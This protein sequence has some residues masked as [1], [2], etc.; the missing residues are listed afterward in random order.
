[1]QRVSDLQGAEFRFLEKKETILQGF[2]PKLRKSVYLFRAEDKKWAY[3]SKSINKVIKVDRWQDKSAFIEGSWVKLSVYHR[4]HLL[5]PNSLTYKG[6]NGETTVN[7]AIIPIT[8][9]AY[10]QLLDQ[11]A[12]RV[13]E[14]IYT[15]EY[16]VL[17]NKSLYISGVK[18]L[19]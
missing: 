19:R 18:W 13:S 12:G 1:M 4:V 10:K 5:F 15:F 9:S 11:M 6:K 7:E 2:H 17:A 16:K 3:Y 8:D 14:S